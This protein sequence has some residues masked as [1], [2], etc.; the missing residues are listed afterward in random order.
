[1]DRI[2][3]SQFY[4]RS[5]TQMTGLN[6]TA[7]RLQTQI[8][9]GKQ[10]TAASQDAAGWSRLATLK[11]DAADDDAVKG[12]IDLASGILAQ[13][14]SVL[15]SVTQQVQRAQEL[16]LTAANGMTGAEERAIIADQIDVIKADLAALANQTDVRGV[17][18]FGGGV[19]APF[20]TAADGSITYVGGTA[21]G[22]IPVANGAQVQVTEDGTRLAEMFTAL[23]ALSLAVRNGDAIADATPAV[24]AA[25]DGVTSMRSSIGARAM[26]LDMEMERLDEVA[27]GREEARSAIEDTDVSA[28]ITELQKTLTI[29]SATQSSFSRL[30]ALSLFDQL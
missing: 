20:A 10:L 18:M 11:R 16:A 21:P 5:M 25:L 24:D 28:A 26:R 14:D 29:L 6:V 12:N 27:L 22:A 9:T 30:S 17:A 1:M 3:T 13:A 8:A 4:S 19:Q 7:D 23:E 15:D 2:A